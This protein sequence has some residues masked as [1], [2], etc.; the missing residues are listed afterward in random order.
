MALLGINTSL[1]AK[2]ECA[3]WCLH[4]NYC[5]FCKL[6]SKSPV[7]HEIVDRASDRFYKSLLSGAPFP[8]QL[9]KPPDLPTTCMI[10]FMSKRGIID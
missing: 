2:A 8:Q 10:L 5:P 4:H 9:P 6:Y 7:L 3:C 1:V